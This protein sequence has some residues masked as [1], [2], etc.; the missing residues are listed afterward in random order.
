MIVAINTEQCTTC[1]VCS[2][3]CPRHIPETITDGNGKVT[4]IS[5]ERSALCMACGHCVAVCPNDAISVE[6][7]SAMDYEPARP[8]TISDIDFF[9]LLKK[10][11][12]IRRYTDKPVPRK[13]ISRIVEAVS[14]APTGTGRSSVGVIVI[15]KAETLSR[16]SKGIYQLYEGLEKGLENPIGRLII[17]R[18][19]GAK[20]FRTMEDFLMPGMHWY[21][22]WYRE[23]RSNEILR[24]CPA[25]MLFHGPI[26][27]PATEENCLIAAF[28]AVLMAEILGVGTCLNDM[29]PPACSRDPLLRELLGLPADRAV[30]ASLTM[31]YSKYQFKRVPPRGLAEFRYVE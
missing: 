27:E 26:H 7:L 19:V 18:R 10:R 16:F 6:G 24:D 1:G 15:D 13:M 22:R 8:V 28:H 4:R 23:G 14:T 29:I 20:L 21:I 5:P 30:Y 25:V 17:K 11:R 31:G 3:I 9:N 2:D 12:S